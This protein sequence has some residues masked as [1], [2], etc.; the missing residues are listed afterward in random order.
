MRSMAAV[1]MRTVQLPSG[2]TIPALG[3]GTWRMGENPRKRDEELRALRLGLDLGLTL[4]DTAEMY[5]DGAAEELVADAIDGRRDDVFLVSKVLP[6]NASRHGTIEACERSLKRLRTDRIDLYL[7]HWRGQLPL[8]GTVEALTELK[9]TGKIRHWGVS[10]FDADDLAELLE[11]TGGD[12]VATNQVLYNLSRRQ[13]EFEL[14]PWCR[15]RRIP[16]MA[17]SPVDR[18]AL[19]R[20]DILVEL[21][22]QHDATPAQ[23]ALAWALRH[24]DV[25]AIPKASTH[26]HVRENVRA[27]ELQLDGEDLKLLDE[28]FPPPRAPSPLDLY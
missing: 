23:V 19:V 7:L 13:A 22:E 1:P 20:N 27:L 21:A 11:V 24:D 3:Q 5:A 12:E 15:D 17:Y 4:I 26:E 6:S 14:L 25:C 2:E 28:E 8:A 10:N 16:S 18:G 9:G